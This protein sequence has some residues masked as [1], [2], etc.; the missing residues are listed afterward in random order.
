[1]SVCYQR[2]SFHHCDTALLRF[3][4]LGPAC[5]GW[6]LSGWMGRYYRFHLRIHKR[7]KPSSF[8]LNHLSPDHAP[9]LKKK[10]KS[11]K[12]CGEWYERMEANVSHL[13]MIQMLCS[14]STVGLLRFVIGLFKTNFKHNLSVLCQKCTLW[15]H[16][17]QIVLNVQYSTF[18]QIIFFFFN[19]TFVVCLT[20]KVA[21]F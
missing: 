16:M 8:T 2:V 10:K 21:L 17:W 20:D 5:L 11:L 12:Y 3:L 13:S 6:P 19:L 9:V 7:T 18:F 4:L 1:M 15:W 14:I